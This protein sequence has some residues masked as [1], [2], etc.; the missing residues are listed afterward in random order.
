MLV[1]ADIAYLRKE[2]EV[3]LASLVLLVMGHQLMQGIV[4]FA[5]EQKRRIIAFDIVNDL[6]QLVH[7]ETAYFV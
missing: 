2:R 1:D 6:A 3:Y 5:I 7:R 4:I